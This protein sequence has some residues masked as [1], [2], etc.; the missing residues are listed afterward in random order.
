MSLQVFDMTSNALPRAETHYNALK[1][2][3]KIPKVKK[4]ESMTDHK[5]RKEEVFNHKG[6]KTFIQSPRTIFQC[7]LQHPLNL[8]TR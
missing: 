2:R 4:G 6:K 7:R 5:A 3:F 8:P 1:N